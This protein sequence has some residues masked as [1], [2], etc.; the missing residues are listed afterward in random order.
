MPI[1]GGYMGTMKLVTD[2][3]G[4]LS[5]PHRMSACQ[6][7]GFAAVLDSKETEL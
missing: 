2:K 6:V 3:V 1:W 7:K 4:W 5:M